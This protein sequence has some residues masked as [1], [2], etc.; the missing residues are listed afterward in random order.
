MKLII[1]YGPPATGKLTIAQGIVKKAGYKLFDNH[2][3]M[4]FLNSIVLDKAKAFEPKIFKDFF[5]LY[6]KVRLEIL[7]VTCKL[8]DV[9]GLIVT[10]AYTGKKRF[11][12]SM[13]KIA[14]KNN[15][16]IY[17]IKLR[18]DLNQLEKRVYG[19]SR[20]KYGKV[21]NKKELFDWL[22]RVGKKS[23]LIYP[24]RKTLI[25]DN[26]ELSIN[27]SVKEVLKFIK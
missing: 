19:K 5:E 15:C 14:E 25:L 1:L 11:I 16:E 21:K 22:A 4:D 2:Q 18:C 8:K 20:R 23:D 6:R 27:S 26:T 3:T 10:E 24:Y 7:K 12:S 13:I 17:L 9:K